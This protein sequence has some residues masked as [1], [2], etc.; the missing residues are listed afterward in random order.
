MASAESS[1]LQ[2]RPAVKAHLQGI[3][4]EPSRVICCRVAWKT[5]RLSVFHLLRGRYVAMLFIT[6][7]NTP[8][9]CETDCRE[10]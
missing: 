5:D 1:T 4:H 7:P 10:I 6:L 3:G 9:I 8:H 2:A